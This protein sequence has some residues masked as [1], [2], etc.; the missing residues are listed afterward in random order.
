MEPKDVILII[1]GTQQ[2]EGEEPQTMELTTDGTLQSV[3]GRYIVTYTESELTGL[4]GTLTTFDV[5]KNKVIL[6]RSGA[7]HSRMVFDPGVVDSSLY[8]TGYGAVLME[9][10]AR[11]VTA[12]LTDT[13]GYFDIDYSVCIEQS[14]AGRMR[15]HIEVKT[16]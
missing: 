10:R 13:G 6:T 7:I 15:Y 2:V 1:Q 16:A 14:Y 5:W 12:E 9:V 3:E 8:D 4:D 11:S